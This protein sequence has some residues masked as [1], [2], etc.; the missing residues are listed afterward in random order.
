MF[1]WIRAARSVVVSISRDAFLCLMIASVF[2]QLPSRG[3]FAGEAIDKPQALELIEKA[4]RML[5]NDELEK[6]QKF[7]LQAAAL[8]NTVALH[9]RM[10]L[11][12]FRAADGIKAAHD[13][14]FKVS[15]MALD[16]AYAAA[17]EERKSMTL[18]VYKQFN[19]K[20]PAY[21]AA[22]ESHKV[23]LE[24]IN[25]C[26]PAYFAAQNAFTSVLKLSPAGKDF[27]AAGHEA[28]CAA[29]RQSEVHTRMKGRQM[30]V[31]FLE[32]YKPSSSSERQ[33]ADRCREMLEKIDENAIRKFSSPK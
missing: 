5:A 23:I 30:L 32:T 22:V 19:P 8:E 16:A 25:R 33:L 20:N 18:G 15:L 7:Y 29:M 6:S 14:E 27:E 10:A 28:I 24:K 1:T 31:T 12:Y 17:H 9:R 13:T 3:C 26:F 11:S 21:L 4:E 2:I